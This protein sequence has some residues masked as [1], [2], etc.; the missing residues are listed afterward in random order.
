MPPAEQ[1]LDIDVHH[2]GVGNRANSSIEQDVERSQPAV[3]GRLG[4]HA[5]AHGQHQELCRIP[6][7]A[8]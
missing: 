8:A 5:E 1:L 4:K 2:L 7:H 3:H 6:R